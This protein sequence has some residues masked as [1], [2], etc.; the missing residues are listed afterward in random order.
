MARVGITFEQ[1]A[2][3]ADALLGAGKQATI[4]A[5]RESLGTGSPNTVHRHLTAWRAARPQ[6]AAAAFE[7]PAGLV[8]AL[9]AELI[10]AGAQGRSEVEEQLVQ[11]QAEAAQLA[12][13]GEELEE[14][15]DGL[16]DLV[17]TLTTERDGATATANERALEIE[18]QVQTIQ[19][20]QQAA[21]SARVELAKAQLKIEAGVERV[22]ELNSDI[23][24]LRS[25]LEAAQK[26]RQAA[27]QAAAVS[28]AQLTNEQSKSGDLAARLAAAEKALQK[29]TE[30]T[31]KAQ[32]ATED[33]RVSEK[34][35][36]AQLDAVTR[37]LEALRVSEKESRTE[38]KKSAAEAAELR[39]KLASVKPS[40]TKLDA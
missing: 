14:K 30:N 6:T 8:N 38:A 33:A 26:G 16:S 39:G 17:V 5:V 36:Q 2:A 3:A 35:V 25:A 1:V 18:R 20:E 12:G 7:L 37:D 31:E 4:Q 24:G 13:I 27:E 28:A 11:A 10:R 34:S 22:G 15:L 9:G 29:A 40:K 19:R 23:K 32:R 21:E